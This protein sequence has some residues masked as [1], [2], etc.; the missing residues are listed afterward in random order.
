MATREEREKDYELL[1]LLDLEGR[2]A[3]EIKEIVRK[4]KESFLNADPGSEILLKVANEYLVNFNRNKP[5]ALKQLLAEEQSRKRE[6]S[7]PPDSTV[8]QKKVKPQETAGEGSSLDK[9]ERGKKKDT[10]VQ[11]EKVK[12]PTSTNYEA[13]ASSS[14]STEATSSELTP[15]RATSS[16]SEPTIDQHPYAMVKREQFSVQISENETEPDVTDVKLLPGGFIVIADKSNYCI[17]LF[18]TQGQSLCSKKFKNPPLSLAVFDAKATLNWEVGVSFQ[19]SKFIFIL[20]VKPPNEITILHEIKTKGACQN[21]AAFDCNHLACGYQN[22]P[23]IDSINRKDNALSK[24]SSNVKPSSLAA[25]A[26]GCKIMC[27]SVSEVVILSS[28]GGEPI[29]TEVSDIKKPCGI[30]VVGDQLIIADKKSLHLAR[31]TEDGKVAYIRN[32]WSLPGDGDSIVSVSANQEICVCSTK[33][34]VIYVLDKN[35]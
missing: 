6:Q 21:L 34:G 9:R 16:Q 8:K 22:I 32:L 30:T 28:D 1:F 11:K 12:L 5:D 15:A 19:R 29:R 25:T 4:V 35:E 18:D 31:T 3:C 33:K 2:V 17:K 10:P 26:D 13:T 27:T 7:L 14:R 23:G 20:E 24:L